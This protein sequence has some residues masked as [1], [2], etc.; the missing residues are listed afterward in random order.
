MSDRTSAQIQQLAA[1]VA[2]ADALELAR[3]AVVRFEIAALD[4]RMTGLFAEKQKALDAALAAQKEA[5]Q[6]AETANEKRF[7]STNEW[8]G[9]SLDRERTQQEQRSALESTFM[10][11]E[12]SDAQTKELR[13]KITELQG[14][15]LR[16][17]GEQVGTRYANSRVWEAL[18][19]LITLVAMIATVTLV[20]HAISHP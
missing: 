16:N 13:D 18:G 4:E 6:K 14:K 2:A 5:V 20:I 15:Q 1:E 8:R 10:P 11:R 7:E 12:V 9:Q 19:V 3:I 17:T